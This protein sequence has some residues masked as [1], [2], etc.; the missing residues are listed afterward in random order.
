[1][2]MQPL[3]PA[4]R[5]HPLLVHHSCAPAWCLLVHGRRNWAEVRRP[6]AMRIRRFA[7]IFHSQAENVSITESPRLCV[8]HKGVGVHG[9]V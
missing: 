8:T 9:Q 5:S 7:S 2:N 1:M 6:G 3:G 4:P